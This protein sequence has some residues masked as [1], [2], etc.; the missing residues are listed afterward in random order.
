MTFESFEF[1]LQKK[2]KRLLLKPFK[3]WRAYTL[4][5][6]DAEGNKLREPQTPT[7]KQEYNVFDELIRRIRVYF[8]KYVPSKGLVRFKIL[9]EF[10]KDG[11]I[12]A[13]DEDIQFNAVL[14]DKQYDKIETFIIDWLNKYSKRF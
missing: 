3:Y 2:M 4:G 8:Y 6:I 1:Y 7:E 14:E 11:F 13:L 10:L 9:K 5:I 12:E